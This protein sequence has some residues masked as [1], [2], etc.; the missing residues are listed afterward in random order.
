MPTR[1]YRN[2]VIAGY[3]PDPSIAR[4]GEDFYLVNSSFEF[5]PGVPIYHSRNLV[6]WKLIG[7]CLTTPVQDDLK[8]ARPSGGIYAPTLRFHNGTWFM[9]VT[10]V[11]HGGNFIV[12]TDDIRAGHWS[13]PVYVDQ[14]GIDPS[15]FWDDDGTCYYTSSWTKP[16]ESRE[17]EANQDGPSIYICK[18]DPET[19]ERLS[20]SKVL[21][22]GCGG[23]CPEGPHLYKKDGVYY[24]M[25]A[26]GGTEYGHMET[27]QRARSLEGPWEACPHNPILSNRD[28]P[29]P[30]QAVGHADLT[31]DAAGNL[32][33][34][35]LGIRPVVYP[36]GSSLMLHHIGRETFLAPVTID[37]EGWPVV[38]DHGHMLR[39]IDAPLPG[40]FP[41]P[42]NNGFEDDFSTKAFPLAWNPAMENYIRDPEES[43]LTLKGT[44]KTLNDWASPTFL[45]VR[46]KDWNMQAETVMTLADPAALRFG[47][48]AGITAF[49]CAHY[50]YDLYVTGLN[51]RIYVNVAKHVHDISTVTAAVA[52]S[53]ED[54]EKGLVFRITADAE[55]YT[56]SFAVDDGSG[57]FHVLDTG[58]TAALSTES[59]VPMTFTG[60]Y[61]G[62]FAENLTASFEKFDA[63]VL[64]E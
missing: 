15:L 55:K 26:E 29:G 20:E 43:S 1:I 36:D 62:L 10:N 16:E 34:V 13:D 59:T 47:A 44:D 64:P 21:S 14:G 33:C 51:D 50:H 3:A 53:R 42:V 23:K 12:H 60:V 6:N 40:E 19:G 58:L 25:I 56:F 39:T 17:K 46:Q 61:F 22:T 45:G 2:P 35:A 52:V 11:T 48:R 5:F 49:Y 57:S 4:R 37:E 9:T 38:G 28:F 30:I 18:V 27:F 32:W 7:Y 41:T 24:L 8:G 63:V 54:L 31:D